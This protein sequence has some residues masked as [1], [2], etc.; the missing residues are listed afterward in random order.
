MVSSWCPHGQL[1]CLNGANGDWPDMPVHVH[2]RDS[3]VDANILKDWVSVT[4][5]VL[6]QACHCSRA[7][8]HTG[9]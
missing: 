7:G 6:S 8:R 5:L 2:D 3:M 9:I 4:R 1:D